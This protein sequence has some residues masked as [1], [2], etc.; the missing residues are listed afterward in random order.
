MPICK[1]KY[2]QE[3]K[4]FKWSNVWIRVNTWKYEGIEVYLIE[5]ELRSFTIALI[6][7]TNKL[8]ILHSSTQIHLTYSKEIIHDNFKEVT[9]CYADLIAH[10][11]L[12]FP[13]FISKINQL[14]M[15][16]YHNTKHKSL[17]GIT[18]I[19]MIKSG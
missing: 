12:H 10:S 5:V 3:R 2:N 14:R 19:R 16:S 13:I 7:S 15:Q 9:M 8:F 6:C 18:S 11:K 4:V 17:A 1:W